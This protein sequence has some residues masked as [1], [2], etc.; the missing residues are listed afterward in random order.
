MLAGSGGR[1]WRKPE[2]RDIHIQNIFLKYLC[3]YIYIFI[4]FYFILYI[5]MCIYWLS[6]C[7]SVVEHCASRAKG[8]GFSS[9]G[10]HILIINVLPTNTL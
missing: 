9:Q 5:C 8:R 6:S 1:L 3:L 4:F 2:Y 10:T 7:G